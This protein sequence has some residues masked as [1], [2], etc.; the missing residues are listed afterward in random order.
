M[1]KQKSRGPS[2]MDTGSDI[3]QS[4]GILLVQRIRQMLP[5]AGVLQLI[6][7]SQANGID[8]LRIVP[9]GLMPRC[10]QRFDILPSGMRNQSV[11]GR[12]T[13][14]RI[15]VKQPAQDHS[16]SGGREPPETVAFGKNA[17][18][19]HPNTAVRVLGG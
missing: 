9:R 16:L 8:Q 14:E 2:A 3:G 13:N 7:Q 10:Q 6:P 18:D 1:V 12:S 17:H 4:A 11:G 15:R 19:M 5:G